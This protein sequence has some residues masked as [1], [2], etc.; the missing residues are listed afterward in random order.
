MEMFP[1]FIALGVVILLTL[2]MI[3][4]YAH[5][6]RT[7][8]IKQLSGTDVSLSVAVEANQLST[9]TWDANAYRHNANFIKTERDEELDC[10]VPSYLM[11]E[12]IHKHMEKL[13]FK[14]VR[15]NIEQYDDASEVWVG[16][17][18][19]T[20]VS[21]RLQYSSTYEGFVDWEP[22]KDKRY[23]LCSLQ[24]V[25]ASPEA[26]AELL[27][28]KF[29][30]DYR[31]AIREKQKV[32]KSTSVYEFV[33]NPFDSTYNLR[34][35]STQQLFKYGRVLTECTPMFE[36]I[37]WEFDGEKQENFDGKAVADLIS[38]VARRSPRVNGG[39]L[40]GKPGTGKTSFLNALAFMLGKSSE[41]KV[42]MVSG[43]TMADPVKMTA[44]ATRLADEKEKG[45]NPVIMI[46]EGDS[47]MRID[48]NGHKTPISEILMNLMDLY[49]C[50]I[51]CN[52]EKNEIHEAF[53]RE[54]RGSFLFY[55]GNLTESQIVP[56]NNYIKKVAEEEE[57]LVFIYK[58]FDSTPTLAQ[59]FSQ[60]KPAGWEEFKAN[61]KKEFSSVKAE[62]VPL[63]TGP[64]LAVAQQQFQTAKDKLKKFR[65]RNNR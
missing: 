38:Y 27:L 40:F 8:K 26:C 65:N 55:V 19:K 64:S 23:Y 36:H 51:S 62:E 1:V 54:G 49:P 21:V 13:T 43:P 10:Q 44:L 46:N 41:L 4:M 57:S 28:T 63:S 9:L 6:I 22:A 29:Q 25:N 30:T 61:L 47:L 53:Y 48:Q 39:I 12:D 2:V 31:R 35:R 5:Y 17:L 20:H 50:Y 33:V 60:L 15:S 3:I 42:I 45:A 34:S 32:S 59:L 7:E 24:V 18:F 56:V 58:K 52:C 11:M 37:Q 14:K 16:E